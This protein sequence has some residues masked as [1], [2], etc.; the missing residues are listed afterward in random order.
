MRDV[1]DLLRLR[2]DG[3]WTAT[4]WACRL[5]L[6]DTDPGRVRRFLGLLS[7]DEVASID[8]AVRLEW[9]DEQPL[10]QENAQLVI[11]EMKRRAPQTPTVDGPTHPHL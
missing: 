9:Y 10:Y 4:P 8:R 3:G 6:T 7:A 11:Q 1:D 2:R 5:V